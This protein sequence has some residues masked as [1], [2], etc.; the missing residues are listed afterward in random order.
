MAARKLCLQSLSHFLQ[1]SLYFFLP[2]ASRKN[3]H[4]LLRYLGIRGMA[5]TSFPFVFLRSTETAKAI[6]CCMLSGR[7]WTFPLDRSGFPYDGGIFSYP[8]FQNRYCCVWVS[9]STVLLRCFFRGIWAV[10]DRQ[11]VTNNLWPSLCESAIQKQGSIRKMNAVSL[12]GKIP[13]LCFQFQHFQDVIDLPWNVVHGAT[14]QLFV[15]FSPE[16]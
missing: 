2:H 3:A 11:P 4:S 13:H 15:D 7:F 5:D 10:G 6:S 14:F 12:R 16:G 9:K 8:V 1:S